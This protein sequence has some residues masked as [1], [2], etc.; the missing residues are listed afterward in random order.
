M[1]YY[2]QHTTIMVYISIF[3][4]ILAAEGGSA[5]DGAIAAAFC[6]GVMNS[7]SSG[8]GGGHFMTISHV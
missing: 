1:Y 2:T 8:I 4:E 7:H 5:M 6:I 3:S